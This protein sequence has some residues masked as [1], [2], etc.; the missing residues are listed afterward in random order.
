MSEDW[1]NTTVRGHT[2]LQSHLHPMTDQFGIQRLRTLTPTWESSKEPPQPQS[3]SRG[4]VSRDLCWDCNTAQLF[5][6]PSPAPTPSLS[7]AWILK[8]L[9]NK[10]PQATLSQSLVPRGPSSQ[11]G[12]TSL[13]PRSSK[14]DI[15]VASF[16]F[17]SVRLP[18]QSPGN[19]GVNESLFCSV[20]FSCE[21]QVSRLGSQESESRTRAR[22]PGGNRNRGGRG[23]SCGSRNHGDGKVTTSQRCLPEPGRSVE[24]YPSS[25]LS[26]PSCI[27]P[28]LPLAETSQGDWER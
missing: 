11:Q 23:L 2:S 26:P 24:E 17:C 21:Q 6:L 20:I 7:Q 16:Y 19:G 4:R 22:L 18:S 8:A 14:T 28:V 13:F 10:Y 1:K 25:S 12:P 5:P 3:F 15:L 27:S 9:L